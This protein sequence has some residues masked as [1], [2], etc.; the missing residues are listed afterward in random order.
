MVL[1]PN[2]P[3][4]SR[5]RVDSSDAGLRAD[6]FL[7]LELPFLS[8]T[9]L[10]QKIQMGESLLNGRRYA[11]STRLNAGDEIT[12]LWRSLP[13]PGPLPTLDVLFED[14]HLLAVN[15]P[16]GVAS[17]PMGRRQHGTVVQWARH[18]HADLIREGLKQGE[19][20]FY[21]TLANRLDVFTS[22]IV[23]IAKTRAAH[24]AI[25]GLMTRRLVTKEYIALVEG[26]IN[27]EGVIDLPI[28]SDQRSKVRVKMT[29]RAG[30]QPSVTR[31]TIIRQLPGHT[32]VRAF[33][34][35]GRQH[36]IRVHFAA[37]GHPVWGDLLYKD[38]RLFLRY[39]RNEGILDE[40]LPAR[41]CLHATRM[42]FAHPMTG[43]AITIEAPL[44]ADFLAILADIEARS[45]TTSRSG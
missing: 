30:G 25:Q 33:P 3:L 10:R 16:A 12:V 38:E 1:P 9:R 41:Q 8:R 37:I 27:E 4:P 40:T 14:P 43:A 22:G 29:T 42:S 7:F 32:L 19:S 13:G 21:P 31:Y 15:K 35:T 39:Q 34:L 18:R 45:A 28:N 36:Q 2:D 23:L 44:P 6:A 17:H 20:G 24:A 26:T 5:L 11:T